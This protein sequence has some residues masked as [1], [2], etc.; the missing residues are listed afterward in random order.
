M[1]KHKKIIQAIVVIFVVGIGWFH[2]LD[3]SSFIYRQIS[4]VTAHWKYDLQKTD[5]VQGNENKFFVFTK[6]I[7]NSGIEHLISNL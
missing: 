4:P 5:T 6:N 2:N 1:K 7:I 3:K